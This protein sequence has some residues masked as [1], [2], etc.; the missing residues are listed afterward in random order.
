MFLDCSKTK[1]QTGKYCKLRQLDQP[2]VH[3]T[4]YA[5]SRLKNVSKKKARTFQEFMFHSRNVNSWDSVSPSSL[6]VNVRA[7]TPSPMS[8]LVD[9]I[10]S[11]FQEWRECLLDLT[12][13][14]NHKDIIWS[15]TGSHT[16]TSQCASSNFIALVWIYITTTVYKY[17][18]KWVYE[19]VFILL[20]GLITLWIFLDLL[21]LV[22]KLVHRKFDISGRNKSDMFGINRSTL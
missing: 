13:D 5:S 3:K 7:E 21:S 11:A 10:S 8:S 14:L 22:H 1:W 16:Y 2:S 12:V 15:T 4:T 17:K 6:S 20:Y 19:Y 9:P 18:L